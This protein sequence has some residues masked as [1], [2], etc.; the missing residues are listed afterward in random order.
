MG[1]LGSGSGTSYPSAVDT[2][3]MKEA[4]QGEASPTTV[5]AA[6]IN[7]ANAA[8]VAIETEL[9]ISPKGTYADVK[10]RLDAKAFKRI[11]TTKDLSDA[12]NFSVTSVGFKPSSVIMLASVTNNFAWSNGFS[13]PDMASSCIYS[14]LTIF[15]PGSNL[16]TL[17]MGAGDLAIIDIVSYD[18]DG[19][20]FSNTRTGNPTGTANIMCLFL[21]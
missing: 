18:N 4:N 6:V 2:D 20:T 11:V 15:G 10:T 3:T 5:R 14:K 12:N 16:G 8:I 1:E 17:M 19:A 21:R 13:D 9:G 7:D